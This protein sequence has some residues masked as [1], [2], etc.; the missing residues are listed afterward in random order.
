LEVPGWGPCKRRFVYCGPRNMTVFY[1]IDADTGLFGFGRRIA[2]PGLSETTPR[3][4]MSA[5]PSTPEVGITRHTQGDRWQEWAP[6]GRIYVCDNE[7][8]IRGGF[9]FSGLHAPSIYH[10]RRHLA[11][12]RRRIIATYPGNR[13]RT[14][15]ER[16]NVRFRPPANIYFEGGPAWSE[17]SGVVYTNRTFHAD[18]RLIRVGLSD[19]NEHILCAGSAC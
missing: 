4:R 2:A 8:R 18:C 16:H 12:P 6:T 17:P 14:A 5:N 9:I 13:L 7:A 10:G 1:A 3:I 15:A 19:T 11:A